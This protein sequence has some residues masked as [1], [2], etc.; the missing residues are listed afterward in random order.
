MRTRIGR[1]Q[2]IILFGGT[3]ITLPLA[4]RAQQGDR[5]R[6]IGVL[7]SVRDGDEEARLRV[8]AFLQGLQ[9]LGWTNGRNIHIDDRSADNGTIQAAAAALVAQAPDVLV[10]SGASALRA[11]KQ[12]THTI[13]IVFVNVI[14]PVGQGFVSSLA[15]PR[16]NVT[17]FSNVEPE[18]G[19]TWLELLKQIAPRLT[20]VGVLGATTLAE[21]AAVEAAIQKAAP[22]LGVRLVRFTA[23]LEP[24]QVTSEVEYVFNVL[25]QRPNAGLLVLPGAYAQRN[26]AQIIE[27]AAHL[28]LPAIY[29]Y[30]YYVAGG[31]LMSYGVDTAEAFRRAAGYVDRILHGEKPANMPVQE[32]RM[33][34]LVINLQTAKMLGIEVPPSLL[35]TADELIDVSA[36]VG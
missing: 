35:E 31:G 12:A 25:A 24:P 17:G 16:G 22:S 32:A 10:V 28:R 1:R 26:R 4:A 27:L 18:M 33:F 9:E 3:A 7:M 5:L 15:Q 36:H 13:P 2:F 11:A 23:P 14:D 29:P 30:R 6:R 21:S 34:K 19:A 8:A 20:E